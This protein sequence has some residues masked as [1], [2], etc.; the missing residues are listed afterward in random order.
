MPDD[1]SGSTSADAPDGTAG[2]P[3]ELLDPPG[4]AP[5]RT[6]RVRELYDLP[7]H[8]AQG[9]EVVAATSEHARI[10]WPFDDSLVG[11][12]EVPA[13]HGGV[14]S[15]LADLAGA[16]P[17][18][19]G[20]GGYTPTV[21]LRVDYLAHAERTDLHAA[22][23]VRRRGGSVGVADVAV[24]GG[25]RLRAKGKGVYKLDGPD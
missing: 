14:I 6:E 20:R 13:V 23:A 17:F 18:V 10:R 9:L 21:D 11:N 1:H 25:G 2:L 4:D 5:D 12:P 19:A 8:R 16:A 3:P 22:A 24:A 7:F 15:A